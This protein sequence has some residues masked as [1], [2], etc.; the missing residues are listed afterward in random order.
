ME[1]KAKYLKYKQKY[2]NLIGGQPNFTIENPEDKNIRDPNKIYPPLNL[3]NWNFI[4]ISGKYIGVST[5]FTIYEYKF[6]DDASRPNLVVMSGFSLNSVRESGYVILDKL[7]VLKKKYRAVYIINL[8]PFKTPQN[9]ACTKRDEYILND[10][11]KKELEEIRKTDNKKEKEKEKEFFKKNNAKFKEECHK[12]AKEDTKHRAKK[13]ATEIQMYKDASVTINELITKLKLEN[14][15]LL[16][17]CAGGGLAIYTV[18]QDPKYKALLLAVPS[19]PLNVRDLSDEVLKRVKFRFSWNINDSAKF[20]WHK[21]DGEGEN[22]AEEKYV[23]DTEMKKKMEENKFSIDY[24]S[25]VFSQDLLT[26]KENNRE[27]THEIHRKFID[28]IANETDL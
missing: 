25:F 15:H 28:Y 22:S 26:T 14:V 18:N 16:G 8:S 9:D 27:P 5:E 23:Y 24:V 12:K 11:E 3:V 2:L 7:E 21:M 10:E 20:D 1:F 6:N 17:E 4:K 13:N 19:S